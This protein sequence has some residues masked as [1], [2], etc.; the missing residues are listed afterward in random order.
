MEWCH[1]S[2]CRKGS[3]CPAV[4][5]LVVSGRDLH[6]TQGAAAI[7]SYTPRGAAPRHFCGQCGSPTPNPDAREALVEIPMGTLDDAPG[8]RPAVRRGLAWRA[9]WDEPGDALPGFD[10]LPSRQELID[11][12]LLTDEPQD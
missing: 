6:V 4:P 11:Q 2:R 1:C 5:R 3:G 7:R 10:D 12:G 9:D 8:Q